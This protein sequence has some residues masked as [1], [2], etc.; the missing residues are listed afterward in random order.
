MPPTNGRPLPL[1]FLT[2]HLARRLLQ[3]FK[4]RLYHL[5][6]LRLS[7]RIGRVE[8]EDCDDRSR[9]RSITIMALAALEVD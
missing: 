4:G 6:A 5:S 9:V 1:Q 8:Y 2:F 7:Q 3:N